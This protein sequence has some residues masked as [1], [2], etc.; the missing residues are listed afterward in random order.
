MKSSKRMLLSAGPAACLVI[1]LWSFAEARQS[2]KESANDKTTGAVNTAHDKKE[3]RA[4]ILRQRIEL[5]IF[6]IEHDAARTTLFDAVNKIKHLELERLT[7]TA[8][9][10]DDEISRTRKEFADERARR[11]EGLLGRFITDRKAE[12]RALDTRLQE[13]RLDL[14]DLENRYDN[15]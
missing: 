7:R 3:L 14:E 1:G 15:E 2:T 8:E 12:F 9:A 13:M 4:Q 10:N 5:S 11:L 6:E